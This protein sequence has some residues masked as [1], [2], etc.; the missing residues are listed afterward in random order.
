[1]Y[2]ICRGLV[3]IPAAAYLI[4]FQSAP[5][6]LKPNTLS[7]PRA[8]LFPVEYSAQLRSKQNIQARWFPMGSKR[9]LSV[10]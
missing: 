6:G 1:M 4:R 2:G 5:E 9:F 10:P 3:G 8:N 7:P